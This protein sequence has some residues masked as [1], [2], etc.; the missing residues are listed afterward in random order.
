M[1]RGLDASVTG[2]G[3]TLVALGLIALLKERGELTSRAL[4]VCQT[5]AVMQWVEEA[6]RWLKGVRVES[7]YGGMDRAERVQ[8]YMG[9]FDVLIVGFHMALRDKKILVGLEPG[10]VISDDVDPLLNHQNKTHDLITVLSQRAERSVVFNATAV[11]TNLLQLHAATM[12]TG[13]FAEWGTKRQFENHFVRQ[14]MVT[15]WERT[16]KVR[17]ARIT[18]YKNM[19]EFRRKL[20]P[21]YI[22]AD[23]TDFARDSAMPELMPPEDVWLDLHPAQREKYTELQDGVVRLLREEG[24]QVKHATALTKILYGGMVCAGLPALQE[25]D[26]PGTSVKLDWLMTRLGSDWQ[27]QKIVV[28]AKNL[29][30]VSAFQERMKTAGIGYATIWGKD[31]GAAT[32]Q[33]EVRRFWEDPNCRVM[34]GTAAIE[35]SLN[36]Q[37]ANILV[38]LDT[39]LNPARMTQLLGRIRRTGSQHSHVFVF[40]LLARDTQEERYGLVLRARQALADFVWGEDSELYES[41]SATQLLQLIRP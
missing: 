33:A 22:R 29:G 37:V 36:L 31:A 8:R 1:G 41:L 27:D 11:Q 35:R 32:R 3:K 14:E 20:S 16:R 17:K 7:V 12:A 38:N 26:G 10:L 24:E 9:N 15:V 39:H 21:M 2:A 5:P 40:N 34:V 23:Y 4:I 19:E 25:P 13:G 30:I 18:G 6:N 28:F